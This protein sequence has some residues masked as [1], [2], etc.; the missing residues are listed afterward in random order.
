M[1]ER[2]ITPLDGDVTVLVDPEP[3]ALGPEQQRR[4][5]ELWR[6]E[7]ELRPTL[8]DTPILT[9]VGRSERTFTGRWVPY[10]QFLAGRRDP[11]LEGRFEVEGFF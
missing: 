10:R 11:V 9:F 5:D 4:A 1:A 6:E 3:L 7:R 8:Q 2:H